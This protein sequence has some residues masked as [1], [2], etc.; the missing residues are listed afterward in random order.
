MDDFSF[1]H[2]IV[3]HEKDFETLPMCVEGLEHV[4]GKT[5]KVF[6]ISN[7]NPDIG[8]IEFIDERTFDKH[9]SISDVKSAFPGHDGRHGWFYQQMIKMHC[10]KEIEFTNYRYHSVDSDTIYLSDVD[11]GGSAFTH[12][13]PYNNMADGYIYYHP[14]NETF[15]KLIGRAY[16]KS[17]VC[18]NMVFDARHLQE[19]M[20]S[21]EKKH[22]KCFFDS[23]VDTCYVTDE[24]PAFS[25]F[26]M[27]G[28][29]MSDN[30]PDKCKEIG[31]K[32]MDIIV[33]P[34]E[35]LREKLVA[36]GYQFVSA[37]SYFRE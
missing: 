15:K 33:I 21:V 29:W 27:Y 2:L 5:G 20:G 22:G 18:H 35:E 8:G 36:E 14:Y 11:Y 26:E 1:D 6:V 9:F 30:H 3:A 34:N 19:M 10:W 17:Y 16:G 31:V 7:K 23:V 12:S 25:E 13:R 24:G 28:N 32:W 4:G 37:H